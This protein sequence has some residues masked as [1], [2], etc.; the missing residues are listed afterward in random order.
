MSDRRRELEERVTGRWSREMKKGVV[1]IKTSTGREGAGD[2]HGKAATA[3]ELG[4]GSRE[5]AP[6]KRESS[7]EK[8]RATRNSGRAR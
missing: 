1:L 4:T 3:M 6:G 2:D 8:E 5:E 7:A